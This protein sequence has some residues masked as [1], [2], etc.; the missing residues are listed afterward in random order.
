MSYPQ[1]VQPEVSAFKVMTDKERE[2]YL[3]SVN[4][5]SGY[6]FEWAPG[7]R[8]A[9]MERIKKTKPIIQ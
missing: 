4:R 3:A 6:P 9:F 8:E 1:K 5:H 2:R 7:E